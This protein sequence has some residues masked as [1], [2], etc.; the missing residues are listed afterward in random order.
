MHPRIHHYLLWIVL[1]ATGLVGCNASPATVETHFCATVEPSC[2]ERII[3]LID[4]ADVKVEVAIYTFT[5]DAVADALVRAAERDV[6]VWVV[7]ES[8]QENPSI[9]AK[10]EGT[11]VS[12]RR[13]SNPDL[14]HHKFLVVDDKTVATG[15][16]NWTF[17][18]DNFHDENLVII[19]SSEVA[20][21][22]HG[23]FVRVWDLSEKI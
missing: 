3:Q 13:D 20:T 18:A 21:Q 14:M 9:V 4:G 16:F 8:K 17:S 6:N 22:F 2:S 23:E 19:H 10:M 5:L 12:V 15:S 7:F 11:D 1:V